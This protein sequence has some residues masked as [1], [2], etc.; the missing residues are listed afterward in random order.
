MSVAVGIFRFWQ[1]EVVAPMPGGHWSSAATQP[2]AK[3]DAAPMGFLSRW[4]R[5][6]LSSLG[7]AI[8]WILHYAPAWRQTHLDEN[9]A[10]SDFLDSLLNKNN[11]APQDGAWPI[12][13]NQLLNQLRFVPPAL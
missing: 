13:K 2:R 6:A 12:K 7:I 9:D 11:R 4:A 10:Y 8:P 3:K 5:A 1:G